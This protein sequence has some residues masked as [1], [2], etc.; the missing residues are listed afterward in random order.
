M[1]QGFSVLVLRES[2]EDFRTFGPGF[3]Q[4]TSPPGVFI[5]VGPP[6]IFVALIWSKLKDVI[7][8]MRNAS[9]PLKSQ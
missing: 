7:I 4:R 1:L 8:L 6:L 5:H 2:H 3:R 9:V